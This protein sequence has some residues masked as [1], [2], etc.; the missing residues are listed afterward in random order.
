MKNI[1]IAFFCLFFV[2]FV[3]GQSEQDFDV[4]ITGD[5]VTITGYKG[6]AKDVVIPA[7]INGKQVSAIGAGAF[8]N[9]EIRSVI[10]PD[11][12]TSIGDHAFMYDLGY[13]L[14][15]GGVS[16]LTNIIIP[17]SVVTIGI[18]AFDNCISL[19]TIRLPNRLEEISDCLFQDC[20]NLVLVAVPD[21]VTKIGRSAFG[22]T[23][24]SR[25]S[26]PAG[27]KEVGESAFSEDSYLDQDFQVEIRKK[28][29][30]DPFLRPVAQQ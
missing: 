14:T 24:I 20:Q 3:F 10:I 25:I 2:S 6:S 15:N 19:T 16:T 11:G 21:T 29:G 7:E 18:G 27:L 28:F 5:T 8:K 22:D 1:F 17:D 26:L 23:S 13:T 30:D 9:L 12:V 4:K